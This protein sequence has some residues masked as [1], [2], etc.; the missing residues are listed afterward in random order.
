VAGVPTARHSSGFAEV[1]AN[2]SGEQLKDHLFY[3]G[4][5]LIS[6]Y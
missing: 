4:G 5:L 2:V 3:T 6:T 1:S